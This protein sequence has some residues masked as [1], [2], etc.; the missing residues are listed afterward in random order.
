MG[1]QEIYIQ[2]LTF[3]SIRDAAFKVAFAA[4]NIDFF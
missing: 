3:A 1:F 2:L 4:Y